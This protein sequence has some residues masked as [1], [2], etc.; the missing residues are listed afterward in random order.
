M[1]KPIVII[2]AAILLI[3]TAL[4]MYINRNEPA[5][6]VQ[7]YGPAAVTDSA[8]YSGIN[9]TKGTADVSD[10]S[11][12][13]ISPVDFESLKGINPDI[14]AWIYIP[15]TEISYPVLQGENN[16]FYI[17]HNEYSEYS[18][19][20]A[21]FTE[22]YNSKDFKD[23]VTLIYGHN[24][25]DESMFGSLQRIC[26]TLDDII[27]YLPDCEKKYHVFAAVPYSDIHILYYYD[28]TQKRVFNAFF[29]DI[30][31]VKAVNSYFDESAVISPDDHIIILSTCMSGN[32][33]KRFLVCAKEVIE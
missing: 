29:R 24:M 7:N 20:G 21:I 4:I 25:K 1:K 14:Y 23:P 13:Y 3:L 10:E 17:K 18:G 28:F 32:N 8:E 26:N 9:E 6:D 30:M 31:S 11:E 2:T 27:I 5:K 19:K 12:P 22:D 15:D 16:S 33:Q